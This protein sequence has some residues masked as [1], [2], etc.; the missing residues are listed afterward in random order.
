MS[1]QL[2]WVGCYTPPASRMRHTSQNSLLTLLVFKLESSGAL[3]CMTEGFNREKNQQDDSEK[4]YALHLE[5]ASDRARLA[6][7]WLK[8]W[9]GSSKTIFPDGTK[10]R[11]V[12]PFNTILSMGNK[13]KYAALIAHQ[14]ALSSCMG[15][16]TTWEFTTNLLLDHPE[17]KSGLSLCQILM[18]IPS[19]VRS[20]KPLFHAID[21][22]WRSENM[23][24]FCYEMDA[25]T[26]IAGLIPFLRDSFNPWYLSAFSVEAKLHHQSSRWDQSCKFSQWKNQNFL[27][28]LQRM[29]NLITLTY[30]LPKRKQVIPTLTPMLRSGYQPIPAML[31]I[32]ST[33]TMT[34]F[35]LSSKEGAWPH[36]LLTHLQFFNLG[37][38]TLQALNPPLLLEI[39]HTQFSLRMM[40]QSPSSQT[41]PLES[42]TWNPTWQTCLCR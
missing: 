27:T 16:G 40:A 23:V 3:F 8:Q 2:R 25:R 38:S 10:M 26:T 35:L 37:I 36:S 4:V 34:Q 18:Q 21:H 24:N 28:F 29:M 22:Q 15:V 1:L 5:A 33:W 14:G 6:R 7:E 13:G 31:Q 9:Y 42:Q 20:D 39:P 11:L 19:Q 41:L 30:F 17:P 12:P 32:I